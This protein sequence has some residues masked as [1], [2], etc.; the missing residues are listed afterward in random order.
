MPIRNWKRVLRLPN[1]YFAWS[2]Y[3][4]VPAPPALAKT[5]LRLPTSQSRNTGLSHNTDVPSG[6]LRSA[7]VP[8]RRELCSTGVIGSG[9]HVA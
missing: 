1:S 6:V 2:V 8:S 9:F 3:P 4:E 7:N 5:W